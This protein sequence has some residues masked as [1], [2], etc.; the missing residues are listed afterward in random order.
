MEIRKIPKFAKCFLMFNISNANR[1]F[2]IS[3][4][5]KI[6]LSAYNLAVEKGRN[7]NISRPNRICPVCSTGS[8]ENEDHFLLKCTACRQLREDFF[9][10]INRLGINISITNC[11][12]NAINWYRL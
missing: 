11:A 2:E 10:K 12:S 9:L 6:R 5:A 1:V 4:L 3:F 7:N 8:V